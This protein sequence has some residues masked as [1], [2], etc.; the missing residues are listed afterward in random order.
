M[1]DASAAAPEL[2][3]TPEALCEHGDDGILEARQSGLRKTQRRRPQ[4]AEDAGLSTPPGGPAALMSAKRRKTTPASA[5]R[6]RPSAEKRAPTVVAG[7]VLKPKKSKRNLRKPM[8]VW[9]LLATLNFSLMS[10]LAMLT[11]PSRRLMKTSARFIP[12]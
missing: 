2:E 5:T 9:L 7:A 11:Q 10:L 3:E 6:M 4:G 12:L 8:Q 1:A